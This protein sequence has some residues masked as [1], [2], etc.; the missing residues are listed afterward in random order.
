MMAM[1][2]VTFGIMALAIAGMA[3]GVLMGRSPIAGSCGGLNA[4]NG[5]GEC[6]SCSRPC[7]SKRAAIAKGEF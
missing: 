2:F 1:F 7:S 6:Q 5:S 3:I 4:V